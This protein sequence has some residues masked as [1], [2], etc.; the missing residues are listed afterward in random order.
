MTIPAG[1]DLDEA[2]ERIRGIN[3][4]GLVADLVLGSIPSDRRD[5]EQ[6]MADIAARFSGLNITWMGVPAFENVPNGKT[7]LKD[8]GTL[9]V[10]LDPYNHPRRRW[11]R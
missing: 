11:R 3:M 7:I 8:A 10:K 4:H 6:Y 5:R 9:L 2:A 1:G